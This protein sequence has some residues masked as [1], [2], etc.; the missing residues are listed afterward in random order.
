MICVSSTYI[1]T[2]MELISVITDTALAAILHLSVFVFS[3][4]GVLGSNP[5]ERI[6]Y[7][8][9]GQYFQWTLYITVHCTGVVV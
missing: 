8:L 2:A 4:P 3:N 7:I 6:F 5:L 1:F 9:R